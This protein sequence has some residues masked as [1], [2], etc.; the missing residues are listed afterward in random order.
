ML[1]G[2]ERKALF[3]AAEGKTKKQVVA[4]AAKAAGTAKAASAGTA[5]SA[6]KVASKGKTTAVRKPAPKVEPRIRTREW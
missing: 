1:T 3:L 2:P 4:G 5:A 6:R